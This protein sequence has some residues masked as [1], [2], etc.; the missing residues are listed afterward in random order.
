MK[1]E[2]KSRITKKYKI[3]TT[4][5]QLKKTKKKQIGKQKRISKRL[6][7]V[8]AAIGS[9]DSAPNSSRPTELETWELDCALIPTSTIITPEMPFRLQYDA[10][11]AAGF[12]RS[13]A[14]FAPRLG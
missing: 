12:R 10:K 1:T 9:Q 8:K 2:N 5:L 4:H 7:S 13:G 6:L 3:I 11:L 14:G